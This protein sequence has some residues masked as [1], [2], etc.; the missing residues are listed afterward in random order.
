MPLDGA[1][2]SSPSQRATVALAAVTTTQICASML[3]LQA[4]N[5]TAAIKLVINTSL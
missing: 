2:N 5:A 3:G 1:I 4:A